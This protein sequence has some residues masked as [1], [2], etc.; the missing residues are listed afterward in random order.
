MCYCNYSINKIKMMKIFYLIVEF[1]LNEICLGCC[2]MNWIF[3]NSFLQK[4]TPDKSGVYEIFKSV[5]WFT[6][7]PEL[8]P[9]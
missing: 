5:N 4:K 2:I 8:L 3:F 7:K 9:N 1:L 6:I